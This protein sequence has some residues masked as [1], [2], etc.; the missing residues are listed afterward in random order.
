MGN[1]VASSFFSPKLELRK[2]EKKG[3]LGVFT[4]EAIVKDEILCVWGG[5]VM[6]EAQLSDVTEYRIHH[7][8]QIEEDLYMVP[9]RDGDP[10][11]YV[12]HSCS[13]NAG[14]SG[15]ICLLALRDIEPGEEICFDYAMTDSSDYDEFECHCGSSE[16]RCRVTGNDWK[17]PELQLKY[18]GYFI[19]YLQRRID[20]LNGIERRDLKLLSKKT[21]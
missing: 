12:N 19:S 11:D 7:A 16:C 20:K 14:I 4:R 15:Q 9:L 10:A 8:L 2:C 1:N 17:L 21:A 13:P 5:K 3:G 6:T 18:E